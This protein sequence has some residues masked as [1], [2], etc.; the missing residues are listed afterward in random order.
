MENNVRISYYNTPQLIFAKTNPTEAYLEWARGTGKTEGP[1]TYRMTNVCNKM[2]RSNNALAVASYQKFLKDLLGPIE[3]GLALHGLHR[4]RDWVI[5]EKPP[6]KWAKPFY[7]PHTYDYELT[8]KTGAAYSLMSQDNKTYNQGRSLMSVIGDEAKLLKEDRIKEDIINAMRGGTDLYGHLPEFNSILYTSDGY[9]TGKNS[10]WFFEARKRSNQEEMDDLIRLALVPNPSPEVLKALD[11]ARKNTFFYHKASA[12][13]NRHTLGVKYFKNNF[14]NKSPMEFLVSNLN[15][16]MNRIEGSYYLFLNE[17]KQGYFAGSESYYQNLG[18]DADKI[19]KANC[20]GDTDIKSYL[21]LELS[22]DFGGSKNC[23]TISQFDKKANIFYLLKDYVENKYE[24]IINEFNTYY[25]PH[26]RV[27]NKV[28]IFY[29]VSGNWEVANSKLNYIQDITAKLKALGW[30]VI[31]EQTQRSYIPH[32]T[33]H[34]IWKKVLYE[35]QDRDKKYP[36]FRYNQYNAER[37]AY[38]M[39]MAPQIDIKGEI[40]KDKSSEKNKNIPYDKATHLSD[41]IDNAVCFPILSIYSEGSKTKF[42][43]RN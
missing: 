21:P 41:A 6:K 28:K 42:I 37:T 16:D 17:E 20:L 22:F 12:I 10:N 27:N 24:D 40:R 18:Y 26:R 25:T 38:S 33:K 2:W 3:K 8:F 29:D 4:G 30:S 35:G 14:D 43:P 11:F 15:Y 9:R 32:N 23:A 31:L 13:E 36:L 34:N 19:A 5:G 7:P 39:G 1:I